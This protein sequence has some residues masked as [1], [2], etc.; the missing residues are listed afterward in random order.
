MFL[1]ELRIRNVVSDLTYDVTFL[2][3]VTSNKSQIFETICFLQIVKVK[4]Q[5]QGQGQIKVKSQGHILCFTI[6]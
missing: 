3:H 1:V 5:S 2:R 4:G 6:L